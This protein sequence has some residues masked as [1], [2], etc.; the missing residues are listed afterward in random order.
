MQWMLKILLNQRF[1]QRGSQVPNHAHF[2]Q[3][4]FMV[5]KKTNSTGL[6]SIQI[7]KK[8][9]VTNL[10]FTRFNPNL[11]LIDFCSLLFFKIDKIFID[12]MIFIILKWTKR[13][14]PLV[15]ICFFLSAHTH[16]K[17]EIVIFLF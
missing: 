15:K 4:M 3:S 14:Y 16:C 10:E 7:A 17:C 6:Y 2:L 1:F 12:H 8:F 5:D 11:Q 13:N 9:K